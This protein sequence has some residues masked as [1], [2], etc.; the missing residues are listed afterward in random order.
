M[1]Q[2]IDGRAISDKIKSNVKIEVE[3]LRKSGIIEFNSPNVFIGI[4]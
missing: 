2:L 3:N 1:A 4:S